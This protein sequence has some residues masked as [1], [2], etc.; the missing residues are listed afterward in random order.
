MIHLRD[1]GPG[2]I[3][4]CEDHRWSAKNTVFEGDP[5]I[6]AHIVL[7]LA[8]IPIVTSAP[9]TTFWPMLQFTPIF[10]PDRIWEKCQIFVPL[11]ISTPA[12]TIAVS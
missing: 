7:Y 6:D 4:V 3:D 12:S 9:T 1:F 11:P 2:V 8:L 5:F 10:D